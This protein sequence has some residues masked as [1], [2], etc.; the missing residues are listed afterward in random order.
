MVD[1]LKWLYSEFPDPRSLLATALGIILAALI[2]ISFKMLFVDIPYRL[3]T[4]E[5][6]LAT[7]DVQDSLNLEEIRRSREEIRQELEHI[8]QVQETVLSH[9]SIQDGAIKELT[10]RFQDLLNREQFRDPKVTH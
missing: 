9:N 7:H 2:S 6:E 3:E 4:V 1:R 10:S 8:R 5:H